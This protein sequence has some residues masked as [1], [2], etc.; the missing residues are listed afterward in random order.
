MPKYR[1]PTPKGGRPRGMG[2]TA[3]MFVG[4]KYFGKPIPAKKEFIKNG[5]VKVTK[6]AKPRE[7]WTD[8]NEKRR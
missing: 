4:V 3:T 1:G 7:E 8:V 5:P 6:P 2:L